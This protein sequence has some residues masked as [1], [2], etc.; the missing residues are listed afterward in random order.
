MNR[1]GCVSLSVVVLTLLVVQPAQAQ[2]QSVGDPFSLYY[3]FFLPRQAA[4]SMNMGPS[5]TL[6]QISSERQRFSAVERGSLYEPSQPFGLDMGG[7]GGASDA[8]GN[9]ERRVPTSPM[10][11]ISDNRMGMG[12]PGYFNR[13]GS[14]YPRLRQS[15]NSARRQQ[16]SQPFSVSKVGVG[17]FG[18]PTAPGVGFGS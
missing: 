11:L 6:N 2:N 10:G 13:T 9:R 4:M 3:G 17:N 14:Y 12:V 1:A 7:F 8:R 15:V 5:A 18:V 16:S